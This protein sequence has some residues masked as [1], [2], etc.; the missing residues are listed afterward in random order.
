MKL[1]YSILICDM[2]WN[3]IAINKLLLTEVRDLLQISMYFENVKQSFIRIYLQKQ[4]L[5]ESP[6]TGNWKRR[7]ARGITCPRQVPPPPVQGRY[8]SPHPR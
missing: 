8:P 1:C 7:T 6:P 3:L 5:Q 4:V 2:V